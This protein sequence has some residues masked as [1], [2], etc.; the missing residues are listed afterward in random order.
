MSV[1]AEKFIDRR[2]L[3]PD[4]FT[5][6]SQVQREVA[7]SVRIESLDKQ[8]KTAGGINCAFIGPLRRQTKIVAAVVIYDLE[9]DRVVE[10]QYDVS[11][12]TIP[13]VPGYLSFREAPAVL[14]AIE[15]LSNRPDVFIVDG[16]GIAHPRRCGLASHIGVLLDYPTIGCAKSRLTGTPAGEPGNQRGQWVELLDDSEVI[17]AVLRTRNNIK[18]LFLSVGNRITLNQTI[19]VVLKLAC[20]YRLTEPV[21]H[22]D[23]YV[24]QL[25]REVV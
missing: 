21:R 1:I 14:A 3:Y 4:D 20:R 6:A 24:T 9:S 10:K 7:E 22:A 15:K 16:Q 18:P 23:H 13:Y 11:D 5:Q 19:E 25:R 17:G 8:V 12:I 2:Y